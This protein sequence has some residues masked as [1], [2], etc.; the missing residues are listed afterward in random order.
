MFLKQVV[1]EYNRLMEIYE[2]SSDVHVFRGV[3]Y[4]P[5][6]DECHRRE[7]QKL[8][9]AAKNRKLR[10]I[11]KEEQ[12]EQLRIQKQKQK[13]EKAKQEREEY[14]AKRIEFMR[15]HKGLYAR[16]TSYYSIYSTGKEYKQM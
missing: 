16:F 2:L 6:I 14:E 7:C 12:L 9:V 3:N 5:F 10:E 1:E 4:K 8:E 11:A 15:A 13:E